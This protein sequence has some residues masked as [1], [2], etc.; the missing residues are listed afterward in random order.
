MSGRLA[1]NRR[2]S[3]REKASQVAKHVQQQQQHCSAAQR[4]NNCTVSVW[5]LLSCLDVVAYIAGPPAVAELIVWVSVWTAV[6]YATAMSP[7]AS[8]A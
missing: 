6:R 4:D 8:G 2:Q 1:S 3:S 5:N 7:V